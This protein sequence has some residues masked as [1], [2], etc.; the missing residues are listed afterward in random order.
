LDCASGAIP[1]K[2]Y[3]DY[4][5]NYAFHVCV[6]L[7]LAALQGARQ[8]LGARGLYVNADGTWLPFK[9]NVF[10]AILCSHTLYHVPRDEQ[11]SMLLEFH[12]VL[13]P[14]ARCVVYYNLGEHSLVGRMLRPLLRV[15][16]WR[17][18]NLVQ[19]KMY[20]HHHPLTWF[21]QFL[22]IYRSV[23]FHVYRLLPN[24]VFKY[25]FPSN[26][27]FDGLGNLV[28]PRL[29]KLESQPGL[30]RHAQYVTVV[31]QK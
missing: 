8:R 11:R 30:V 22:G 2:E 18:R 24:Q 20:S 21:E 4:S 9:S 16:R 10:D 17:D 14:G 25:L 7:T 19:H 5:V 23:D 31:L 3:L 6:D 29:R 13:R 28:I 27:I 15:K 1:A 26:W 12:R